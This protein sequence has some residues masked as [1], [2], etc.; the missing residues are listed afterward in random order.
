[1]NIPEKSTEYDKN[2]APPEISVVIPAHGRRDLLVRCLRSLD[3]ETAAA[4]GVCVVDDGSGLDEDDIRNETHVSYPFLW[5]SFE[6]PKGRSAARNEGISA[7]TGR[8]VVFLDSDMEARPGFI[9]SHCQ[10]HKEESDIAVVGKIEWPRTG[11]FKRYIGSRGVSK[12]K[13]DDS[14]PPWYFVTGNASIR[15]SILPSSRP[16]DET[17]PGWGGED[18]DLGMQLHT[19]GVA[20]EYNSDAVSFHH[21][22]G[23][24]RGHIERTHLYGMNTLPALAERY[25]DIMRIT[26][27][28]L[29]DSFLWRMLIGKMFFIPA[30]GCA[31]AL[32]FLPLPAALYDYLTFAAYGCGWLERRRT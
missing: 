21:F 19:R 5:R 23:D 32:D 16:F 26:K 10:R 11:A 20:F 9:D 6:N 31:Y 3:V 29:L 24:L 1:M 15:R 25:P 27:L 18:L 14:V 13:P 28:H 30:Y 22:D 8:I 12:L 2:V 7:T 4:F 17:L